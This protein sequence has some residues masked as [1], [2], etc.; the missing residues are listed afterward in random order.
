MVPFLRDCILLIST[1][2]MFKKTIFHFQAAGISD[3]HE[4]LPGPL[5]LLFSLAYSRPHLAISL[6]H[7]GL[8][9]ARAIRAQNSTVIP[10]GIPDVWAKRS[11]IRNSTRPNILFLA[12]VCEEKGAGILIDACRI[13]LKKGLSF[14][15]KI[16]GRASS[17]GELA[18][19]QSKAKG[20]EDILEFTGAVTGEC[21]WNLFA[22]SD[23]FCFPT[24]Y[25]SE[26]F[27]IVA[28]EA[29]MTGLPVVTT[30]WRAMPEVVL[31]GETGYVT[32]VRNAVVTADRLAELLQDRALREKMGKA[33]RARFL[34]NYRV[35]TFQHRMEAAFVG[36]GSTASN[37]P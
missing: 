4:R 35:E 13:L 21:K 5:R 32:P 25:A 23:I 34:Q 27:G 2:W 29:M 37:C 19:L 22:E 30:D 14:S 9:D 12:M 1:R 26:S 36:T 18:A 24:F 17:H 8:R 33:G 28:I 7:H 11:L 15:C 31:N 6:S 3:L 10:N 16:A 20:L